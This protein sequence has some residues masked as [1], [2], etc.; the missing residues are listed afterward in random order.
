MIWASFNAIYWEHLQTSQPMSDAHVIVTRI[1]QSKGA[2]PMNGIICLAL[3]NVVVATERSQLSHIEICM[4][5]RATERWLS[6]LLSVATTIVDFEP[7][8]T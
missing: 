4:N 5:T 6:W 7:T 2:C 3:Y 8:Y 1:T